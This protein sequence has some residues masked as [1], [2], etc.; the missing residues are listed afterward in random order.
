MVMLPHA[1]FAIR[2]GTEC[3]YT[4]EPE[5]PYLLGREYFK[6]FW[7]ERRYGVKILRQ[8]L[9]LSAYICTSFFPMAKYMC[10][11]KNKNLTTFF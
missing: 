4:S 7:H 11:K 5:F 3:A 10:S 8:A 1:P 6:G 9:E 2:L